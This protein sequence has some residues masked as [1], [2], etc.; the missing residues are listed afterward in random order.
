ML[1]LTALAGCV[2]APREPHTLVLSVTGT[3]TLENVTYLVNGRTVEEKTAT[4]PWE[5][6]FQ[7]RSGKWNLMI[8]HGDGD[9]EAFATVDGKL[10]TQG[11][12]GG[13][14]TG[15]VQVSGTIGD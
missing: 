11:A 13:T 1:L 14:G 10:V 3:A 6:T 7:I 15:Q 9:I 12:G 8:R 5:K 4:L 2:G